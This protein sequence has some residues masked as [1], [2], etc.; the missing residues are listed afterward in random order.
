MT[1]TLKTIPQKDQGKTDPH[2]ADHG[3]VSSTE[4]AEGKAPDTSRKQAGKQK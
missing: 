2:A 1:V 3:P 4:A